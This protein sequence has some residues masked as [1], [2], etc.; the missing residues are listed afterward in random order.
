M[1]ALM[2]KLELM[3]SLQ[4]IGQDLASIRDLD[5]LL[6]HIMT[7]TKEVSRSEAS[8]M[9]LVDEEKNE[10]Y[11]KVALGSAGA[12]VKKVRVPLNEKQSIAGWV[13]AHKAPVIVKDVNLDPRFYRKA[14]EESKFQTTN[15]LAVPVIWEDK[16]LGVIEALN[17]RDNKEFT[18]EDQEHLTILAGQAA[19]AI[20]NAKQVESLQNYFIHTTEILVNAIEGRDPFLK[21]HTHRIVRAAGLI[22]KIIELP[23][24]RYETLLY[25]AYFHD[26]GK[27]RLPCSISYFKDQSHPI[28]GEDMIRHIILLKS[29]LPVV[30]HHQE[31]WDGSGFPDKLSGEDIPI[32]ARVISVTEYFDEE[33]AL[34]NSS[35]AKESFMKE[36]ISG[37]GIKYDPALQDPFIKALPILTEQNPL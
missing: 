14:D 10:L 30:R 24:D 7:V 9:L 20:N 23:H 18:D 3:K 16:V 19:V 5:E 22:G 29:V 28:I 15:L 11:F 2:E 17:K 1:V 35:S 21:G 12:E 32:L 13:A 25:G 26:I 36:F 27:L 34:L 33:W 4:Q 8:S 6:N 31:R 37:F